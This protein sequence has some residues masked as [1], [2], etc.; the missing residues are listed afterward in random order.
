MF[1]LVPHTRRDFKRRAPM[2]QL[3]PVCLA[4][5]F[6]AAPLPAGPAEE[7]LIA[8]VRL[9]EQSNYSWTSDVADDARSYQIEGKTVREG[10]TRVRMP[11]VNSLRRKLGRSVTDSQID[12]IFF[13]NVECVIATDAGWQRPDE[14]PAPIIK[15]PELD[16]MMNSGS[17]QRLGAPSVNHSILRASRSRRPRAAREE[18]QPYSN[19]Q[20]ALSLPHE[21]LGVIVGSHQTFEVDGDT[22]SGE[23]TDV[24][25]QL[26][27]V[28]D[29]QD[30]ITPI[31]AAGTYKVWLR[32]GV[33]FRY[34]LKLE[35]TLSVVTP[36]GR[37][38]VAVQQSSLTH[39]H[40]V[41]TTSFL[42]PHEASAKL[43]QRKPA[44][45]LTRN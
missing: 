34:Q 40:D 15:D 19:L 38:H 14:L 9:S 13:G 8:L 27:L 12:A 42:L 29:G 41:G 33:V 21:E 31:R 7:A 36:R 26:L 5:S 1:G 32:E 43:L 22:I 39:I 20:F 10:I 16:S 30:E 37:V 35:G 23:L 11:V 2:K 3:L 6:A 45:R 17:S 18:Q 24:G 28:R 25:A 44:E 4:I